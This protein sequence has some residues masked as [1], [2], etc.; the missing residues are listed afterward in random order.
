MITYKSI[1]GYTCKTES[2]RGII[3]PLSILEIFSDQYNPSRPIIKYP[4]IFNNYICDKESVANTLYTK[5]KHQLFNHDTT[6]KFIPIINLHMAL[7]LLE[8][9]NDC[10]IFHLPN[11]DII[12]LLH[13][14]SYIIKYGN[15][16]IKNSK[17][18]VLD[19]NQ[20]VIQLDKNIYVDDCCSTD[21]FNSYFE[22]S[23][24]DILV[25]D[26]FTGKI[27]D[28]PVITKNGLILNRSTL[29]IDN[30]CNLN[31][32]SQYL[33]NP[34]NFKL[35]GL[36]FRFQQI[37][38]NLKQHNIIIEKDVSKCFNATLIRL[39]EVFNTNTINDLSLSYILAEKYGIHK[40]NNAI[41][42]INNNK[43]IKKQLENIANTIR[44]KPILFT[45]NKHSR[46]RSVEQLK[47]SLGIGYLSLYG[48]FADQF[49]LLNL[50]NIHLNQTM[51]DGQE[52]IGTNFTNSV[53][54]NI[55]FNWV[56]FINN[57]FNGAQFINCSFS[58]CRFIN[59]NVSTVKL[60]QNC[61]FDQ[62]TYDDI[63]AQIPTGQ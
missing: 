34:G 60:W 56:I 63:I 29:K 59:T 17:Y 32:T 14:T 7:L 6:I 11:I 20:S 54:N 49:S 15:N 30:Y 31:T 44:K 33:V 8:I 37:F 62:S 38:A 12:N 42:E 24:Q 41:I 40:Y 5:Q 50:S 10:V 55:K 51:I 28:N 36:P 16:K 19:I 53:F 27:L 43:K 25:H 1:S 39:Q 2:I 4:V 35:I 47:K 22:Y 23:L 52:I 13:L 57:N 45:T 48:P 26:I 3:Y 46:H 58:N 61:N 18:P 21:P 9:R